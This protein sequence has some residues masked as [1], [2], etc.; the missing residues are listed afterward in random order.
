MDY[1]E[2]SK[3]IKQK[4]PQYESV[5]DL[6]LA[7][8]VV[9]KYP[10]YKEKVEFKELEPI[11]EQPKATIGSEV[12]RSLGFAL[13]PV[14]QVNAMQSPTG[15]GIGQGAIQAGTLGYGMPTARKSA[16][17]INMAFGQKADTGDVR[18]PT[19]KEEI[20]GALLTAPFAGSTLAKLATKGNVLA[21]AGKMAGAGY[22]YNPSTTEI[23]PAISGKR[24]TDAV[25][26]SA[27]VGVPLVAKGAKE[28]VARS[29]RWVSKNVG[30]IT[31]STVS[32][33]KRIGADKVFDPAKAQADYIG[34]VIVPKAKNTIVDMISKDTQN[35]V[36]GLRDIGVDADDISTI[37]KLNPK[38]KTILNK[39]IKGEDVE[40]LRSDYIGKK[41][42]PQVKEKVATLIE[43]NAPG[44]QNA[45][46][47]LGIPE[48]EINILS[49]VSPS[50][51]KVVADIVRGQSGEASQVIKTQKEMADDYY[52]KTLD[53][54][55]K[56]TT[57][58]A[59]GTYYKLLNNMMRE[60]WVDK[61]GM[62][63]EGAG[64]PNKTRDYLIKI[65][66]DLRK[67]MPGIK[68]TLAQEHS[69][70]Q[71][72]M[73]VTFGGKIPV[74]EYFTKL[75]EL[76]SAISGNMKF[77]RI[78]FDVQD[79]LRRSAEKSAPSLVKANKIWSDAKNLESLSKTFKK[80]GDDQLPFDVALEQKMM[81]LSDNKKYNL[82]NNWKNI[83]GQ[84][85]MN[86][87]DTHFVG[88]RIVNDQD[89]GLSA[90]LQSKLKQLGDPS[91][92]VERNTWRN[93]LGKDTFDDLDAHF[94]NRDFEL[95][96]N[97]PGAGG[98]IYTGRSGMIKAGVS[99]VNK[100]Y[101]KNVR[102]AIEKVKIS[103][104]DLLKQAF[105]K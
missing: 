6:T 75:N 17:A 85:L 79:S 34:K 97:V 37:Q 81:Q 82:R 35:A 46:T 5:D 47:K 29:G 59:K 73:S 19:G 104:A 88:K 70:M 74:R 53:K 94:A 100:Q 69:D 52:R 32:L 101:Y 62:A 87:L 80:L 27:F 67:T 9:D 105:G 18:P 77:D 26:G 15:K 41:I 23:E 28:V 64:I 57:V 71:R 10:V 13:N 49:A 7:Q 1:K 40:E 14:K 45:M 89:S 63:L 60:G 72:G 39:A 68:K 99:G 98:G 54:L 25:I 92:P 50:K 33:I 30:G 8:K 48:N 83:I 91:K 56:G 43:K 84:D 58:D 55:P 76:E 96:S 2:F 103:G 21:R 44:F 11:Q 86:D 22:A 38:S 16:E 3:S 61:N 65:A 66:N 20:A 4:Y 78:V 31:D 12:K 42:V 95:V 51:R 93:I 24:A 102:P 90:M 36:K